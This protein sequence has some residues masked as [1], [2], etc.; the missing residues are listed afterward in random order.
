MQ[1][2]TLGAAGSITLCRNASN[3]IST[4][5][6]SLRYKT[7]INPFNSGL[8]IINR[9]K[10]ITFNWKDGGMNDLG[11]GAED[12]A[13][14]EENLVIRNEKG[15]VEG[16]KYDRLG[17]VLINA[18]K[19]QQRQLEVQQKLIEEQARQIE[20]LKQLF[21]SQNPSAEICKGEK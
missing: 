4:C 21:C 14:V 16:V 18:V 19:E 7:N 12:V 15:E 3:Q 8:S 17:V 5:S 10:P 13:A 9:L 6:S 11:L 20:L 2:N 1:V